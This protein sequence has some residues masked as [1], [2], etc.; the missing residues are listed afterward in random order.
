LTKGKERLWNEHLPLPNLEVRNH[1]EKSPKVFGPFTFSSK[2]S[3]KL[4]L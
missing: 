2:K 1:Q 4:K 3:A